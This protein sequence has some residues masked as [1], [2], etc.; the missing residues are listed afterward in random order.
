MLK[1]I[2]TALSLTLGI[3]SAVSAQEVHNLKVASFVTPMHAMS[4]WIEKWAADL[5][6]KSDGRLEFTILAGAQMGPPPVY[7]DLAANGVADITWVLHGATPGRFPLTEISNMPFIFC[8]AEQAD[9]VLNMPELLAYFEPE[10]RGVKVLEVF[11]HPPG[12]IMMKGGA[13]LSK[14]DLAG[15][16]LR[17]ASQPVGRFIGAMGGNPVGLPPTELAESLQKSVIDGTMIDYGGAAFAYQLG[18][19]LTDITEMYAYSASFALVMNPDSYAGLPEDLQQM[20]DESV[21][22]VADQIG[23]AWDGLDQAGKSALTKE[24][25]KIHKMSEEDFAEIRKIGENL[26]ASYIEEL[27]G[28]GLPG[29]EVMKLIREGVETVGAIGPGCQ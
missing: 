19:F 28:K 23:Q 14:D 1:T 27:D 24:G 5:E 7:Y 17:P 10:H 3:G 12:H 8:S 22:D 2:L 13:V 6:E 18:P 26:T 4:K 20:I 9:K 16:A 29:S 25:V 21:E 11:M 15:K